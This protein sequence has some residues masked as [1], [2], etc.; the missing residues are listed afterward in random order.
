MQHYIVTTDL[1]RYKGGGK[2]IRQEDIGWG[3]MG[4]KNGR[5]EEKKGGKRSMYVNHAKI[6]EAAHLISRHFFGK[7]SPAG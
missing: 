3:W 4:A 6:R 2:G 1:K 5:G 7:S